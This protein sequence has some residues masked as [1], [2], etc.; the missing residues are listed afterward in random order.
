MQAA[1]VVHCQ[2]AFGEVAFQ[3]SMIAAFGSKAG[4]LHPIA[5]VEDDVARR[6]FFADGIG[7]ADVGA[8][9]TLGAG[10]QIKQVFPGE[11]RQA[12]LRRNVRLSQSLL[13]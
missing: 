7:R 10:V 13:F 11:I 2:R 3:R 8:A 5:K 12:N 9:S 4:R 6:E 1:Q